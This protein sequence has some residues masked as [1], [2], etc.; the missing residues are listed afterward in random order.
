VTQA[1]G[2]AVPSLGVV[3]ASASAS[4]VLL[5]GV[6]MISIVSGVVAAIYATKRS[7]EL[8]AARGASAAWKEER[9]AEKAKVERLEEILRSEVAARQQAESRTDIRRLEAICAD[10]HSDVVDLLKKLEDTLRANTTA[11]EFLA[12]QGMNTDG[13]SRGERA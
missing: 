6:A 1:I 8:Q 3:V 2:T 4:S 9:D 5:G 11:V 10:N 12:K 13:P 7:S